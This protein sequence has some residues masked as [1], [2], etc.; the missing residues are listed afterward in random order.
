MVRLYNEDCF[1]MLNSLDDDSVDCIVTSPPYNKGFF[2]GGKEHYDVW[3]GGGIKYASYEDNLPVEEY[4][5]WMINF[6]NLCVRK[7][8]PTGS[9]FFN[10]KP[11][12]FQNSVY[13]PLKFI[14]KTN[15]KIYQEIIWDR[16]ADPNI[17]NSHLLPNTERIYW[18]VKDKPSVY[19]E[20][21]PKNFN[22]EVWRFMAVSTKEH[23][24]PFPPTL[25][26]NCI[27]LTTKTG[28]T[29]CDPFMGIGTTGIVAKELGRNFIGS[30]IDSGYYSISESAINKT[31]PVGDNNKVVLW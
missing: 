28:D 7:I 25:P 21:L 13:H 15:A 23:P 29:V 8:K 16:V 24:A 10:H 1:K 18:L 26:K 11:I 19:K 14:F 6:I 4:E 3:S 12:R 20:N 31:Q 27:L 2:N 5:R 22:S 30:E 17:N 9:I